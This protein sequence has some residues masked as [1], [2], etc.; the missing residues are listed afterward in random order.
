M[1]TIF[2]DTFTESSD[3]DLVSHTSD[4]GHTWTEISSN[5]STKARVFAATDV[6]SPS[7]NVNDSNI[8][9]TADVTPSTAEYDVYVELAGLPT[10]TGTRT[11]GITGRVTDS[12]NY[13]FICLLSNAHATNSTRLFKKVAGSNTQL[14]SIDLTLAASDVIKLEIK[15][16]TK[17]V[18][19]NGGEQLSSGDNAL[20]SVGKGGL[21]FGQH[22]GGGHTNT[23]WDFTRFWVEEAAA[24][25]GDIVLFRRIIESDR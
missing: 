13:Y 22:V 5:A 10:D 7:A 4:S 24:G 3:T 1:T 16:A 2:D 25:G 18:F 23:N 19:Q 12:S 9:Y 14:G 17:K 11:A 21:G 6:C 20:T 8:G 15:D